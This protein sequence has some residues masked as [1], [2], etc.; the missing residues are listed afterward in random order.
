VELEIHDPKKLLQYGYMSKQNRDA[1]NRWEE[2]MD[3]VMNTVRLLNRNVV[4]PP[5]PAAAS[6]QRAS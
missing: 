2:T 4:P 6:N 5:P 1:E 3:S